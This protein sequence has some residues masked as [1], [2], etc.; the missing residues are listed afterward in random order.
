MSNEATREVVSNV[1]R[2]MTAALA[3]DIIKVP[4]PQ[5]RLVNY[6]GDAVTGAVALGG[7]TVRLQLEGEGGILELK[8]PSADRAGETVEE[9]RE[10]VAIVN[11]ILVRAHDTFKQPLPEPIDCRHVARIERD[12]EGTTVA[13]CRACTTIL[14][15]DVIA[16][17]EEHHLERETIDSVVDAINRQTRLA[18]R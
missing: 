5:L 14:V 8:F 13:V 11:R 6:D 15:H 17:A 4:V 1:E 7:Y 16:W 12:D 10:A 9:L 2:A 3:P 18:R